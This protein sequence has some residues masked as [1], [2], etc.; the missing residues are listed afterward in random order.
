MQI[1]KKVTTFFKLKWSLCY[2]MQSDTIFLVSDNTYFSYLKKK[3]NYLFLKSD[4]LNLFIVLRLL[5]MRKTKKN[6]ILNYYIEYLRFTKCK[7]FVTNYDNNKIFW[8]IKKFI[9]NLKVIIIQ[10]GLRLKKYDIFENLKKDKF[11][12]VDYFLT[13][14]KEVSNLFSKFVKAKFIP[15]GSVE[16]NFIKINKN[17]KYGK[18]S[19]I[20]ISEF[21]ETKNNSF[22]NQNKISKNSWYS[23]EKI[24]LPFLQKFCFDKRIVLKI[25]PRTNE[26]AELEFFS[27]I[28][29]RENF[30]YLNKRLI[31][32]YNE[33]DKSD[34]CVFISST[35]GYESLARNK[36]VAAFCIR[37]L[38]LESSKFGWP[39]KFRETGKFWTNNSNIRK[40]DKIMNYLIKTSDTDWKKHS[41][42]FKKKIMFFDKKNLKLNLILKKYY[43][44]NLK[45]A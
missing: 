29:K 14:N 26:K 21:L 13:F 1:L 4:Y 7:I 17:K 28:I 25:L 3:N 36:K 9:P 6:F 18:K 38:R 34:I 32:S 41:I 19:I 39:N 15:V 16:N 10:N 8:K 5:I 37:K 40:F 30:I 43:E 45:N 2:P 35:L 24:I 42:S 22:F 12:K 44:S 31:N 27:N 33:I 23:P 11:Y 20:F